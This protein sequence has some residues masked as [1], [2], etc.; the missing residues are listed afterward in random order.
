MCAANNSNMVARLEE[1]ANCFDRGLDGLALQRT[2]GD[3]DADDAVLYRDCLAFDA[4][5]LA[6][7]Y[8]D[9]IFGLE[10]G[11]GHVVLVGCSE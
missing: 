7:V 9:S 1:F 4:L 10:I 5:L 2:F 11:T 6:L 8:F 3:V